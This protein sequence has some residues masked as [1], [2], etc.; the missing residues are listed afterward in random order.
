MTSPSFDF[1]PFPGRDEVKRGIRLLWSVDD[2][3][4]GFDS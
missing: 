4:V 2:Y 3:N 1:T